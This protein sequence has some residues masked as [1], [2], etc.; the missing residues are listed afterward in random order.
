[1]AHVFTDEDEGKEVVADGQYVG[2]LVEVDEGRAFVE[3]DP[4]IT[5]SLMAKLGW[6]EADE[7]AYPIYDDA[8]AA[9]TDDEIR[10]STPLKGGRTGQ[11]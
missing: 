1:M 11:A 9:V 10:L 8:V 6:G 5:E 7:D 3:P 4:S 2:V